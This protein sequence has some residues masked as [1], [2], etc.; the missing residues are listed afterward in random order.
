MSRRRLGII[1]THPIQYHV[2]LYRYMA[3]CSTIEPVVFF[4]TDHGLAESF[5]PGFGR[6][7]KYD[8]LLLAGYEYQLVR[9]Y[10]LRRS[11]PGSVGPFSPSLPKLIRRSDID[12]LPVHGY[13]YI[14]HWLAYAT[15]VCSHIPYLLRNDSQPD[16]TDRHSAKRMVK[17][18]LIR[19]LVRG[20]A[21]CLVTGADNSQFYRSYGARPDRMLL[22]PYSV[23]TDRF[24]ESGA[25]GRVRRSIML[26]RLGLDPNLPVIMFAGKFQSWKRPAD[27]VLAVDKL[28]TP[29][30][31]ILNGDGP[32]RP[33][34]K[35]LAARRLW[36]RAL[37]FVNQQ[38][39]GEWYGAADLF[40][41]ASSREPWGSP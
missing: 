1:I 31:L 14:S 32:L 18:G 17:R 26:E 33:D 22:A 11:P 15:A 4:L 35:Q 20:A 10:R 21:A 34:I 8:V 9:S 12:A 7:I 36:M 27:M 41:L 19:P 16:R 5:D 28:R 6:V 37:G 3:A 29:A 23:D 13:N 24:A 2:P 25:T 30:N 38:E 40:V 39:T